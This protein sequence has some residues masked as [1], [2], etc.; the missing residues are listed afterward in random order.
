MLPWC[1]TCDHGLGIVFYAGWVIRYAAS[2][3]RKLHSLEVPETRQQQPH[4]Q[5]QLQ[6]MKHSRYAWWFFDGVHERDELT[7]CTERRRKASATACPAEACS[8]SGACDWYSASIVHFIQRTRHAVHRARAPVNRNRRAATRR[9]EQ[10]THPR[11]VVSSPPHPFQNCRK[12]R[13]SR[14]DWN[15]S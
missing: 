12:P 5:Q 7:R 6:Q 1:H 3:K 14:A 2:Y 10:P 9:D 15:C 11:T 8:G 13:S 4:Q